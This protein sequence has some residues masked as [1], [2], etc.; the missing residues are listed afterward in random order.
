M[1]RRTFELANSWLPGV[2]ANLNFFQTCL[3]CTKLDLADPHNET[4]PSDW[5]EIRGIW[6]RFAQC[7][8]WFGNLNKTHFLKPSSQVNNFTVFFNFS[9]ECEK[10]YFQYA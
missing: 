8:I 3:V 5:N 10:V 7:Q 1:A 2:L 9:L 6:G 4:D